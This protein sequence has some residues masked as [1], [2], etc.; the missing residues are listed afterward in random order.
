MKAAGRVRSRPDLSKLGRLVA[1]HGKLQ[2]VSPRGVSMEVLA[3]LAGVSERTVYRHLSEMQGAPYYLPIQYSA[4]CGGYFYKKRVSHFP[5]GSGLLNQELVALEVARQALAVFDGAT[6]AAKVQRAFEKVSGGLITNTQLGL[7]TPISKLVSIHTPG[8]GITNPN[9]F[10]AIIEALLE[11]IILEAEYTSRHS[12]KKTKKILQPLHLACVADRWVLIARDMA[13]KENENPIRTYVIAR[14]KD[15]RVT[16]ETFDYPDDFDPAHYVQSAFG[17][18]SGPERGEP[19]FV[20]LQ[21]SATGAHHVLERKWHPTQQVK[22]LPGGG[23]EASFKVSHTGDI[24]RWI[25]SFGSDCR[26][27]EPKELR[28]E[29]EAEARKVQALYSGA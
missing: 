25:L 22:N 10:N 24:K 23:I 13:L 27:V 4:E 18:H 21:I 17:V 3:K 8:A 5:L 9:V 12:G 29:I 15:A 20:K 1:I 7:G 2:E 16:K 19:T 28:Q 26:V 14:F 11:K 6:F